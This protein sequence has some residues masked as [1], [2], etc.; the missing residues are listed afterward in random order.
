MLKETLANQVTVNP[1]AGKKGS[2]YEKLCP[3]F[4]KGKKKV[5]LPC[6]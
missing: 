4:S 5:K 1:D 2:K 6:A 3:Q